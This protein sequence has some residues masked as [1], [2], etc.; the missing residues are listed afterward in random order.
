MKD[1]AGTNTNSNN[2]PITAHDGVSGIQRN[3]PNTS[4]NE[5]AKRGISFINGN[6]LSNG[7]K[8]S[9]QKTFAETF[10]K[11]IRKDRRSFGKVTK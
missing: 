5:A 7:D 6:T 9:A 8:E 3:A 4:F 10:G 1:L 2:I 11:S